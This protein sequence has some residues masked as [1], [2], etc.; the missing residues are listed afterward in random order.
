MK[1]TGCSAIPYTDGQTRSY[2][3]AKSYIAWFLTDKQGDPITAA[4][5]KYVVDSVVLKMHA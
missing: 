1:S 5:M 3:V 4:G 2:S